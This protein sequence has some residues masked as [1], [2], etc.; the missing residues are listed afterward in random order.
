[1]R[2]NALANQR[3]MLRLQSIDGHVIIRV[4]KGGGTFTSVVTANETERDTV[5]LVRG[6]NPVL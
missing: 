3:L 5:K 4:A 2:E 6:P 1:M